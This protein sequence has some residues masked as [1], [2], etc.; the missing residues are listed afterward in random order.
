VAMA[1]GMG[2]PAE[3]ATTAEEF[4]AAM[5]RA[6]AGKGPSFIEAALG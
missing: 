4:E 6:M 1:S 5:A 3:R 2:V